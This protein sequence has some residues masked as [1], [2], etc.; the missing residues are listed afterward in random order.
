M[1]NLQIGR[2]E[3][4][5]NNINS[6]DIK[7]YG[8]IQPYNK[9]ISK[10][11]CR[12]FYKYTNRNGT[13][14]TDEFAEKLLSTIPY[15]PVKG[16]YDE[17]DEDYTDH[18]YKNE[19]GRIYG[20]VPENPNLA[21]EK[22]LDEDGVEREYACVDVLLFTALYKEANE[23]I[24]KAQSMELWPPSIVGDWQII[25]GQRYYTYTD[26]CF[27][28]LQVLGDE[29]EPCFE[30]A[31]FFSFYKS[32]KQTI[33]ELAIKSTYSS[34]GGHKMPSVKF[35]LSDGQKEFLLFSALNPSFESEGLIE[36]AI[37]EVYDDYALA[38]NYND[39]SYERIYYTKDNEN[40]EISIGDRKRCFIVDVTEDERQALNAI[41]AWNNGTYE[42][43]DENVINL[44][45]D[46][47]ELKDKVSEYSRKN[48][49][50]A[51][52][53]STL[54]TEKEKYSKKIEELES[55]NQTLTSSL[56]A[57]NNYKLEVEKTEKIAE[58]DKYT[59]VLSEETL[60][61]YKEKIAD[62]SVEDLKKELAFELVE[63]NPSVFSMQAPG[64]GYVP[65][66]DDLTG[67]EAIL[68]KY[69]K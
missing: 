31:A 48:E 13:Y 46:N 60:N 3:L 35:K 5:V 23:I 54:T 50:Y 4:K 53:I 62:Y 9:V 36:Y 14:I 10:A 16:I 41:Q 11:R 15:T 52:T 30:G 51:E 17:V 45:N 1:K 37:C 68:S 55:D 6:F 44:Q 40:D 58:I 19:E 24:D 43:I 56:E 26:A 34:K 69:K 20:I 29:V 33:D 67:I 64:S 39:G 66:E 27:L 21:W 7:I 57:L 8:D 61:N 65:K 59:S 32:L 42:K 22:H 28:G 63:S 2:E 18:G 47:S 25:E 12:I 38:F 49:E